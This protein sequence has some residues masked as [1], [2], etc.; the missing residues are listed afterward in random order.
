MR[1]LIMIFAIWIFA[2]AAGA[3][4]DPT[5][6]Y[7]PAKSVLAGTVRIEEHFGP[8]NYGENPETDRVERVYVLTLS[9]PISVEANENDELNST[10]YHDI[11]RIQLTGD[12]EAIKF[13]IYVNR[14]VR[15]TGTLFQGITGHHYTDVLMWVESAEILAE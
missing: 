8:P 13:S 2:S 6:H 9:S 10:T 5:F 14:R 3:S 11:S 1:R 7:E 4:Q 15:L 12:I